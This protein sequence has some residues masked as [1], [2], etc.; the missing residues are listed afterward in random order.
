MLASITRRILKDKRED[1][2]YEE[3]LERAGDVEEG[4]RRVIVRIGS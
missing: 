2:N 1:I 4:V 3:I